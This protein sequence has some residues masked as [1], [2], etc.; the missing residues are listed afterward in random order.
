MNLE[1][2]YLAWWHPAATEPPT[3]Q[4][5]RDAPVDNIFLVRRSLISDLEYR[6]GA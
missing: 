1:E 4:Y 3:H 6:R 2:I 5:G